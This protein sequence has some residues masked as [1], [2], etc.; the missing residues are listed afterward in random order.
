MLE[1][2]RKQAGW[3][4]EQAA[5]RLGVSVPEYQAIEV[6]DRAPAWETWD[7]I[8]KVYGWG[9]TLRGAHY[10]AVGLEGGSAVDDQRAEPEG[11]TAGQTTQRSVPP[12]DNEKPLVVV[13]VNL[14]P[15]WQPR[16]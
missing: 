11:T 6:G 3:S 2:D 9:Q 13:A 14:P 16:Q 10:D 7:R 15:D 12:M 4:V 8:C 1:H 5:R